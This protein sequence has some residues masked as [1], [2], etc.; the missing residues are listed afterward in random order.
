MSG[1]LGDRVFLTRADLVDVAADWPVVSSTQLAKGHITTFVQ[2]EIST[3]G[4]ETVKREYLYH[5]GAVAVIALDDDL[6]VALVRQYRHPVR[7]RLVEPP[8]GLLDVEGED[9][10]RGI[11]RELA[12][13]VGLAAS[14]WR[15]LVDLFSSPGMA[16]E[17]LRVYLARGLSL[18]DAPDGFLAE[19][20][21]ADMDAVWA[22]LEDLVDAVLSGDV[23]NP[24]IV[25][26]VLAAW[27]ASQRD[28]FDALR[29]A[30]APWPSREHL[31]SVSRKP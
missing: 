12:E 28:G 6:R 9:Y 11:Q 31:L 24:N 23:H 30:D 29:P 26:G 16:S 4:G 2:D 17:T 14:D 19:G 25:S 18:A 8:A 7:H 13:E 27:V 5:P 21:E 22:P 10:L 1:D 20:E 3:P 15:V